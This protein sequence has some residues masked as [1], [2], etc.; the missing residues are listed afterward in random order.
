VIPLRDDNPAHR[1]PVVTVALIAINLLLFV[2]EL[3]LGERIGP[4]LAEA[5]FVP[6][7]AFDGGLAGAGAESLSILL[8]MFLHGGWMHFLGNMLFLWVFGDNIEDELGHVRYVAFYL[9]AGYA[10]AFAHAF[11]NPA[12]GLPAIGA[13]GAIAGVL[14]A[15]LVRFPR[16]RLSGVLPI[17]CLWIPMSTR[18]WLFLP[19]WFL[20]Q[21]VSAL[22]AP[23]GSGSG[24]VAF[25]A[26]LAGFAA[27]PPLLFLLGGRRGLRA[28]EGI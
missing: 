21:L 15:F 13:S 27:G 22:V 28:C 11:A 12:S 24:G 18:A 23:P 17:G 20:L 16:A 7:R 14:G 25:Y 6:S 26:H 9:A 8:S 2:Y 10:A 3:S 1:K 5:A 19:G 4:F